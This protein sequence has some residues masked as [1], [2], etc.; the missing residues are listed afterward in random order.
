MAR[1]LAAVVVVG[2]AA[3]LVVLFW[4]QL[5]DLQR[6]PLIA[7]AVSLRG[8]LT[9]GALLA[10]LVLT[11]LALL[12]PAGRRFLGTVALLLLVF[13]GA[14]VAVL[15]SRGF[16]GAGFETS[17]ES[18]L[19]VLSWNTLGDAVAADEI[20]DLV[21]ES[22]AD[23]VALPETTEPVAEEVAA[24]ARTAGLSFSVHTVAYDEVAKARS[25]SLL[26]SADLGPYLLTG[27]GTTGVLPS[28]VATSTA[29][30]PTIVA[31]HAVAPLPGEMATWRSDLASLSALCLGQNVILAG[32]FNATLDSFA[33]LGSEVT[34][35]DGVVVRRADL[36]L[37]S[38]AADGWGAGAV[39]TWPTGVP[40]ALGTP[41]DHVLATPNWRVSGFRVI[42]DRDGAGS[43]HRPVLAQLSPAG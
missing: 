29:G 41:I 12:L 21:I 10:A 1:L 2:A 27:D 5:F 8:A 33:G 6:A 20:A 4:P 36:G 25:T 38:D 30:G 39:G 13:A 42:G 7:Q 18:D 37:C 11:V 16:G 19:T 22:G 32:D 26:I 17:G 14:T 23:V 43:D 35:I 9:A 15:T 40:P 28:V 31:V 24:R 34:G 3:A